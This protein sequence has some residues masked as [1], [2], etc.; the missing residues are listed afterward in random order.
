MQLG[1]CYLTG[2]PESN[3]V[4][5]GRGLVYI[6]RRSRVRS[7]EGE[8]GEAEE[9]DFGIVA[10]SDQVVGIGIVDRGIS[11]TRLRYAPCFTAPARLLITAAVFFARAKAVADGNGRTRRVRAGLTLLVW[12][13][14]RYLRRNGTLEQ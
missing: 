2:T 3:Y 13:T 9:A 7:E 4:G 12:V 1:L 11:R 10:A 6:C 5:Y 14:A 8:E